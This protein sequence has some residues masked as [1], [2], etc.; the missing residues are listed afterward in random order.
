MAVVIPRDW[1]DQ[2]LLNQRASYLFQA[3]SGDYSRVFSVVRYYL[4]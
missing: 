1:L 2:T 4:A 3:L